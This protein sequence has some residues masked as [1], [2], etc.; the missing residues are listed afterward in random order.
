[1]LASCQTPICD[2]DVN[3]LQNIQKYIGKGTPRFELSL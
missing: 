2:G 3:F 1:V